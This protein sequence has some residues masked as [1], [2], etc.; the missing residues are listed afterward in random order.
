[1]VKILPVQAKLWTPTAGDVEV[2]KTGLLIAAATWATCFAVG[3]A[4]HIVAIWV[5]NGLLL[6]RVL[7]LKPKRLGWHGMAAYAGMVAGMHLAGI[8]WG[9]S[10]LL[11][12]PNLVEVGVLLF[13]TGGRYDVDSSKFRI[14][15]LRFLLWTLAAVA[16][17]TILAGALIVMRQLPNIGYKMALWFLGHELGTLMVMALWVQVRRGVVQALFRRSIWQSNQLSLMAIAVVSL[18][19]F[20]QTWFSMLYLLLPVMILAVF[21]GGLAL[22]MVGMAVITPV[23]IVCTSMGHGPLTLTIGGSMELRMILL[24]IFLLT[25]LTTIY[26]VGCELAA[27][28]RLE[29]LYNTLQMNARVIVTR[30]TLEGRRTYVSPSVTQVLGW[31]PEEMLGPPN[32]RIHVEDRQALEDLRAELRG[33]LDNGVFAYRALSKAGEY[34]WLEGQVQVVRNSLTG[35]ARE[36]LS[37]S[38]DISERKNTE[39]ELQKAYDNLERLAAMDGLTGLTNRRIFDETLEVEWRRS[40]REETTISLLMLDVDYFKA[41]NDALGHVAGDETLRGIAQALRD[42][43]QRPGDLAARYGGE[44]FVVLLPGTSHA[45]AIHLAEKIAIAISRLGLE[46]TASPAG[47]VTASIGVTSF[48]PG[49]E[50]DSSHLV[51]EADRALYAAKRN[52]RNRIEVASIVLDEL[53]EECAV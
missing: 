10:A 40:Q 25:V 53:I 15:A 28:Q 38:M 27:R 19:L 51:Q 14:P 11:A 3:F 33:G 1:M 23:S 8:P 20:G 22:G 36:L 42:V 18:A 31:T 12:T 46:H 2:L 9:I 26:P 30:S 24:Q 41:F 5:V 39:A 17:S 29:G 32:Q 45:G 6:V 37:T 35:E 7:P 13:G 43:I 52:G 50:D 4:H 47:Y 21:R 49:P 34:I 44:E 48:T 16:T